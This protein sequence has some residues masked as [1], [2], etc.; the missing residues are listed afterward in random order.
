MTKQNDFAHK[1]QATW[2]LIEHA[3]RITLLAHQKPDPDA[4]GACGALANMLHRHGK[5]V[6]IIY[7]GVGKDPLPYALEGLQENTHTMHPD[8]I[9]SCD[10]PTMN[11]L[12]FPEAFGGVK[13]VNID[14]HQHNTIP[15]DISF[16][17]TT[18][19]S[20]CELVFHLFK[21]WGRTITP[22]IANM[23]LFG[24]LCDTLNFKVPGTSP[25]TLRI[26]AELIECGANLTELNQALIIHS[27]P[28]VFALWGALLSNARYNAEANAV[29]TTCSNKLLAHY[30]LTEEAL[31]GFI[32]V[33]CQT[34]DND[35]TI[36]FYENNGMSKAS[37]RSKWANVNAIA[38]QFGG[39][40]HV[41][42]SG[43][44]SPLPLEE[45]VTQ[46]IEALQPR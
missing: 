24:I 30:G 34:L 16:V 3:H 44:T 9:I 25:H 40:G 2:T 4:L 1:S 37:F 33:F 7:P 41:L 31:N 45:L 17:D 32:S 39:G 15:A 18:A 46:V 29:W 20:T 23:L 43:V 10:T 36:L 6:E 21:E 38:R 11:R 42:A 27:D 35:I 19:T 8:L 14:H 5:K 26:A 12:Y 13:H 22:D 28:K